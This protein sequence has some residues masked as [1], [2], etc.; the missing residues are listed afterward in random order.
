MGYE[1]PTP[2]QEK[3][4]PLVLKRRDIIAAAQTG[5]GKTAAFS[6]PSMDKLGYAKGGQGPLMLVIT[7]TRELAQQIGEVCGEIAVSTHHRIVTVVGGLSYALEY[8]AMCVLL[9]L[10]LVKSGS[11]ARDVM[12]G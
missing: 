2:V 1:T 9:I 10:G 12:G 5:T 7:P 11:W 6:L 4:I 3:A 8:L